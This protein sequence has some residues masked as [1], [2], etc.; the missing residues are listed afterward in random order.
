[1]TRERGLVLTLLCLCMLV[2]SGIAQGTLAARLM[3]A[4]VAAGVPVTEV[5]IDDSTN[6]ATWQVQP[7]ALQAAAQPTIDAFHPD[8]PAHVAADVDR[9]ARQIPRHVRA[10]VLYYLRDKLGRNPTG[11]ERAAA[12]EALVQAYKD[13]GP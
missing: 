3:A 12:I 4:L 10:Q 13:V 6:P 9:A 7:S 5:E 11:A 8:D 1:M 2:S